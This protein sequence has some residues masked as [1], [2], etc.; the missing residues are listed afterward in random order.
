MSIPCEECID[1]DDLVRDTEVMQ[2]DDCRGFL[3]LQCSDNCLKEDGEE[4]SLCI[5]CYIKRTEKS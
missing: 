5:N 2:C 1:C 4:L 3:C